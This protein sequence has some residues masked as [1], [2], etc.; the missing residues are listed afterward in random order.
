MTGAGQVR[1][2]N[3]AQRA[4][5]E[6]REFIVGTGSRHRTSMPKSD[7]YLQY[8]LEQLSGLGDVIPRRMF[9]GHGLYRDDT[10]FGLVFRETLYLKT[11]DSNRP[12]FEARGMQRFRPYKDRP[13]LS[14]TYYE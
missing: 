8:V 2:Q 11:H 3:G 10:F 9:S 5:A 6:H 13:T 4:S 14:F 12:D 7:E 1:A